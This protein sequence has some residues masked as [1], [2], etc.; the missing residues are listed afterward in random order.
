MMNKLSAFIILLAFFACSSPHSS[1]DNNNY[2]RSYKTAL[3]QLKKNKSYEKN[4]TLLAQSL[5]AI[6]A[7]KSEEKI[8][9]KNA[10]NLKKRAIAIKIVQKLKE[11]ISKAKP[12]LDDQFNSDFESLEAEEVAI[13]QE[14]SVAYF[15]KGKEGLV[16]SKRTENKSQARTAYYDFSNAKKYGYNE[17]SLDSLQRESFEYAHIRYVINA[18]A[19][20][21]IMY[22]WDIDRQFDDLSGSSGP[23]TTIYYGYAPN[24]T[25]VD[26]YINIRFSSLDIDS[27]EDSEEESFTKTIVVGTETITNADGETETVDVTEEIKG[28]VITKQITKTAQWS[29]SMDVDGT[30][31]CPLSSDSF[32]EEIESKQEKKILEGDERAIPFHNRPNLINNELM[33]DDDMA[34]ELIE[35]LY[36][37]IASAIS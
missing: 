35:L 27:S 15:E 26:C 1:L 13:K 4:K 2:N 16:Q 19:S 28:T 14:L 32:T 18:N 37:K 24:G 6:I 25:E 22:N 34:E 3:R 31:N 5:S 33:T 8:Y 21:D 10:E 11:K 12:Y 9:Y 30:R 7:E 17:A 23:L 20:F 36:D 29:V